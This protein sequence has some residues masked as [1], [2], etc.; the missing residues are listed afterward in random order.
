MIEADNV[1]R[2]AQAEAK[3]ITSKATAEAKRI[4]AYAEVN[5]T[6]ALFFASGIEAENQRTAFMY[7]RTLLNREN[8]SLDVSYLSSDSILKTKS[9]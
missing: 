2:T 8:L 9:V 7:I 4:V 1:I 3:L 6:Q 5:G